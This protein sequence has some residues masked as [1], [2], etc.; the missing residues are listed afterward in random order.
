MNKL[1]WLGQTD[2]IDAKAWESYLLAMRDNMTSSWSRA[3]AAYNGLKNARQALGLPFIVEAG[4]PEAAAPGMSSAAIWTPDLDQQAVDIMAMK[5]VI[6]NAIDDVIA[7]KRRLNWNAAKSEW[8]IEG[9]PSDILRLEVQANVPV[10]VD[11][12]TG[13]KTSVQGTIGVPALV[14]AATLTTSVLALPVYYL[15]EAGINNLTDV[16]EQKTLRTITEKSYECVQSGKCTP[17]DAAKINQ[18]ITSG[19]TALRAQ[20]VEQEKA[21]NQPTTDITKAITTVAWV[22]LGIAALFFAAR[23]VPAFSSRRASSSRR[24][25]ALAP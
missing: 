13:Q 16:S 3:V 6:V 9:L 11:A 1:N 25:L 8:E 14:W 24:E 12:K 19:V 4:G 17:D 23:L 18:S 20:K 22:G 2:V 7:G 15:V 21:K 10:L 5:T